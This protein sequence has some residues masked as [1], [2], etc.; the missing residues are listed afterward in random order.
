ML[1]E[2]REGL[3]VVLKNP[4]LRAIAGTTSTSNFFGSMVYNI[5]Q[6]SLRQSI[7]PDRLQG[8]MNAS[9]RFI[10]W[11]TIPIGTLIGGAL[12]ATI[13]LRE[14]IWVGAI[15]GLTAVL[16]LVFSPVRT[17]RQ[18]PP[19]WEAPA[20]GTAGVAQEAEATQETEAAETT[21]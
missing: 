9:M 20:A 21:P 7:T 18:A 4:V 8:R 10:V 1:A 12:A 13:G 17:M 2:I 11:G 14:A 15:G 19:P 5:N 6:V 3:G 16:W